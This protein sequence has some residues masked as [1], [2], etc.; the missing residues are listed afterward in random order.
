MNK[1]PYMQSKTMVAIQRTTRD[2]IL[3]LGQF[4]D[5]YDS[6]INKLIDYYEKKN[7]GK[8]I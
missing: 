7:K 8:R 4:K 1:N 3:E 6:V 2:R 5:T